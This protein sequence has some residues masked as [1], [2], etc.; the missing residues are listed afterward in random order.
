MAGSRLRAKGAVPAG[1]SAPPTPAVADAPT[2][3]ELLKGEAAVHTSGCGKCLEAV[4]RLR[5]IRGAEKEMDSWFQVQP[6]VDSQATAKH[7]KPPASA[8]TQRRGANN[9]EE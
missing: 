8:H 2:Q 1:G 6:A 3:K 4:K 5:N 7:P 9:A